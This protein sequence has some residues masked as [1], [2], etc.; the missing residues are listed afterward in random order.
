MTIR[1]MIIPESRKGGKHSSG[2]LMARYVEPQT[3]YI[4]TNERKISQLKRIF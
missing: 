4:A 3:R 2:I 1:A